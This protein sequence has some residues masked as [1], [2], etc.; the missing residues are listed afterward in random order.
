VTKDLC[1][2]QSDRCKVESE[3]L[4]GVRWLLT[5]YDLEVIW[6]IAKGITANCR[7][8]AY[9]SWCLSTSYSPDCVRLSS[10]RVS[11]HD[12]ILLEHSC[13]GRRGMCGLSNSLGYNISVLYIMHYNISSRSSCTY[14]ADCAVA[15]LQV[16]VPFLCSPCRG[17]LGCSCR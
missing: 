16:L 13:I 8:S 10:R 5:A 7:M 12:E 14:L 11:C 17:L 3:R 2:T 9:V 4:W 1:Q 15:A 6:S